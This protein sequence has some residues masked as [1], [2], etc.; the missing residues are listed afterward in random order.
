MD[1]TLDAQEQTLDP[2]LSHC[3]RCPSTDQRSM[4]VV[5]GAP[6]RSGPYSR[7]VQLSVSTHIPGS[8]AEYGLASI[9]T[10]WRQPCWVGPYYTGPAPS[11]LPPRSTRTHP[12]ECF[13]GRD[14]DVGGVAGAAEWV[15]V[16]R[17]THLSECSA[18]RDVDVDGVVVAAAAAAAA[19]RVLMSRTHLLECSA[20]H[21]EGVDG[22]AAAAAA[23]GA[24]PMARHD[25]AHMKNSSR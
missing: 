20:G 10:T 22:V 17:G 7:S 14:E 24:V 4:V 9:R 2:W 15:P 3:T 13:A 6:L 5:E 16:L 8:A 21:D 12:S 23:E 11:S 18:G 1:G 19:E 25:E